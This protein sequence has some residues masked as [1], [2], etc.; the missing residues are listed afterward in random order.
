M[1]AEY[2]EVPDG[3]LAPTRELKKFFDVSYDYVASLKPKPSKSR[4]GRE[5][6]YA[7]E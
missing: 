7:D 4:A 3:L 1:Q 2:V 6:A 5:Y